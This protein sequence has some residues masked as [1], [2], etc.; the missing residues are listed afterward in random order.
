[1]AKEPKK[2][3]LLFILPEFYPHPGGGIATFYMHLLP[4]LVQQ[5]MHVTVLVGSGLSANTYTGTWQGCTIYGLSAERLQAYKQRFAAFSAFPTVQAHLAAAWAMY[6]RAQELGPFDVVECTD[7]GWG[8]IPWVL[9]GHR[10]VVQFHASIAEIGYRDPV[11]GTELEQ[12]MCQ[13]IEML[14]LPLATHMVAHSR[15]TQG[16]WAS[17]LQKSVHYHPPAFQ[18]LGTE[19][20]QTSNV[21][22]SFDMLVVGRVQYWKGPITLCQAMELLGDKAPN[23]LWIGR[24][25]TYQN[26]PMGTYLQTHFPTEWNKRI[27]HL[28]A[29]PSEE[30]IHYQSQTS[31]I[32]VPSVWDVFNFT[33]VEAMAQGKVVICSTG[34]G[35]ADLIQDG[36]NGF[37]FERDH[38]QA[39]ADVIHKV[40][41]LHPEAMQRIGEAARQTIAHMLAPEKAVAHRLQLYENLHTTSKNAQANVWLQTMLSPSQAPDSRP[42]LLDNMPLKYL[43][44]YVLKRLLQ[45]WKS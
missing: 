27:R 42:A 2:L 5:G 25:T 10:T 38:A 45:K 22:A 37:L 15:Q 1:M 20:H 17:L 41:G 39:L 11:P 30:V 21:S 36:V 28:P 7:W 32:V 26:R 43:V 33:C 31:V 8:Y 4:Q 44:N 34:A 13:S 14:T 6:D 12:Q 18:H 16:F 35:A 3:N 24:E 40:R 19:I 29:M 9:Q 23:V